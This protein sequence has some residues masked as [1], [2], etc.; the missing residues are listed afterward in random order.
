MVGVV[1]VV[2]VETI[3]NFFFDGIT[4]VGN[5]VATNCLKFGANGT[6]NL[7]K[8]GQKIL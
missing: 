8:N 1:V 6:N 5:I 3:L 7:A 2:V 4:F